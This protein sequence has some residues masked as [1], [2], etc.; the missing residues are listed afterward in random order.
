VLVEQ[1]GEDLLADEERIRDLSRRAR[2]AGGPGPRSKLA[3]AV[4][5][6]PLERQGDVLRAFGLYFQLANLAEQHHR[7]R[8]RRQYEHE[9]RPSRE[10]LDAVFAELAAAGIDHERLA[11]AAAGVSLELVLTAHPTEATRRTIL[12]A[13]LRLSRLLRE[14]DDPDLSTAARGRI[15]EAI[16]EEVTALWETDEVRSLRPRVVDEIR[17][18]LWF[19][20]QSLLV[21]ATELTRELRRKL[22]GVGTPLRFGSWIGGDQDGNPAAGPETIAAALDRARELALRHYRAEVRRLAEFVGVASTLVPVLP[23]L[24]ESIEWDEREL[25]EYAAEIGTQNT[26]EPYRRKLSFVWQRLSETHVDRPAGYASAAAFLADLDLVDRSLRANRGRRIADGRL[27][28][29]RTRVE[30]FG[31]H[32]A[33]LDVRLHA[34]D[35]VEPGPRV[36]DTLAAV[37]AAQE[38]H[39]PEALDTL[40]VSGTEG[41]VDV[42]AA[43][44][45]AAEAGVELSVVPLFETIADL[46]AATGIVDE[47]LDEPR[48]ARRVERRGGRM[49]A[50]VGYSDS[51]KDGGYLAAQ[52]AIFEAQEALAALAARRGIELTIFHGRGGSAGRG[53]GPTYAAI[54]AQ[55]T[56]HPPGRLKLTEQGETISFK[57]GLPGLAYRNLEAAL[58][59]TIVSAFPT[60]SGSAP[61]EGA[62]ETL[63]ALA[64]AAH[65]SYRELV[66]EDSRFVDFFRAFT[67]VDE[68]V[69][70]EI[71]SRPARRPG[72]EDYLPRLR[73]IPWVFA[74][75]QNRCLLPAWYGCGTALEPQARTRDGLRDLRRLY[76]S[77]AFFRSLVENLEMT[78]A[79]SSLEIARGYLELVPA[80]L[81]PERRFAAIA[82][83]HARTVE[84][85]KAIVGAN[86]L[87][88][89]QPVLQRSIRLRNPYVDPMNAIQVELLRRH[90]NPAATDEERE[91]VRRP[92]L[93]SIAGI[94]AGLRNTG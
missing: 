61:P 24:A 1:E 39:G 45:L 15:G 8:R 11:Q 46:A 48:F 77:F 88:D 21:E 80:E 87:L 18:G 3:D 37:R 41:A 32:L 14:L 42:L 19:F 44:D 65:A 17:H 91:A 23:E 5:A 13:H 2:R 34:S 43:C 31:F 67:P 71:G 7:L 63:T 66:W 38:R 64:G 29:L 79:K 56:A 85:V 26:G 49:E 10:S 28:D 60:V 74:W 68:L 55:P 81:D 50:M 76:R 47:L 92:L 59:A 6:L 93:R 72:A 86:A 62:R 20:E 52:W 83:E 84:A 25:P 9:G 70:F 35:L 51:G 69:L 78:L 57:Y 73:A 94:A 16:A 82:A 89:R 90:R 4:R 54:L 40:I 22:P 12:T 27:G 30:T 36:R 33:K 75:T 58:A 53:G